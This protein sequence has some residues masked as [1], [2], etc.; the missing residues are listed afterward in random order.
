MTSS[1]F[2]NSRWLEGIVGFLWGV[3]LS[4]RQL[5]ETDK[6]VPAQQRLLDDFQVAS[7]GREHP[8]RDLQAMSRWADYRNCTVALLR[9]AHDSQA[10]AVMRV[11]GIKDP[12][13]R[14]FRAQGIVRA[15]GPILTYTASCRR[16]ASLWTVVVGSRAARSSSCPY[17]R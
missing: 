6:S 8:G 15:S 4:C 12:N 13:T 7:G 16:E 14:S 10:H 2:G 17:V 1:A 11:K 5:A 3:R 9:S